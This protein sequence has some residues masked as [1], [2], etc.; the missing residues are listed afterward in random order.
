MDCQ[1]ARIAAATLLAALTLFPQAAL[2]ELAKTKVAIT[3]GLGKETIDFVRLRVEFVLKTGANRVGYVLVRKIAPGKTGTADLTKATAKTSLSVARVETTIDLETGASKTRVLPNPKLPVEESEDT[4]DTGQAEKPL[5]SKEE[6]QSLTD[7]YITQIN[8]YILRD[9]QPR[10]RKVAKKTFGGEGREHLG[11]RNREFKVV[12]N[13][14]SRRP[15]RFE[16]TS[17]LIHVERKE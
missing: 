15:Y 1:R 14:D 8:A 12:P 4:E 10:R 7:F 3:N 9:N 16:P 17:G 5:L 11:I 2:G 6:L 13:K